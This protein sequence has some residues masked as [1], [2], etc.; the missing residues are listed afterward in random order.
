MTP[1][2]E[3][4]V[5]ALRA[6][7]KERELLRQENERLQAGATEPLAIVG[8]A[9]RF[10]GDV[11]SPDDLWRVV[12]DGRDVVSEPPAGRGWDLERRYDVDADRAGTVTT[13]HGGFLADADAFDAEF[14]GIAPREAL[15]MDP[16]QRLLLEAAWEGLEHAGID[17]RSLAG[18]R[19]GVFAG[20]SLQDYGALALP[21][22]EDLEGLRLTGSLTSVISGR[23]AYV[24]GLEGP[25]VTV[26][27]ACSASLVS[28]HMACQALR[29]RECSLALAGGVT[30]MASPAMFLEFSRQRGLAPDGRCKPFAAAADGVGWAEGAGMVVVERLSDAVRNGHQILALVRGSDVNQD[31]DYK[32]INSN[33]V[34]Y[35]YIVII[36]YIY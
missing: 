2:H 18:T 12:E 23:I 17:P 5:G 26:D 8:M 20:I 36:N 3:E 33:N 6:S 34:N 11:R 32:F 16:Q 21:S 7:L 4:V 31:L 14:F 13:R 35:N 30:V 22:R 15:A 25:A 24:L 27:T 1:S 19:T 9:C 28:L 10:P 29:G